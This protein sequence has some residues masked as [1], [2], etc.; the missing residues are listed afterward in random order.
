M[1][2]KVLALIDGIDIDIAFKNSYEAFHKP[3]VKYINL[4]RTQ[5]YT[6]KIYVFDNVELNEQGYLVNP[7]NH[8]YNFTTH[9]LVGGV[10]N[11]IFE[12]QPYTLGDWQ[13]C[14]YSTPLNGGDGSEI[15]T[16]CNLKEK[17]NYDYNTSV[18]IYNMDHRQVHTIIPRTDRT[19]ILFLEQYRDI[20]EKTHYLKPEF[21]NHH[22]CI[23]QK[24]KNIAE[25]TECLKTIRSLI[26]DGDN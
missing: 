21:D 3:C 6:A 26:V 16:R 20:V 19:T 5:N 17:S 22:N 9:I 2:S 23:H 8:A 18:D 1:K 14:E 7:H 25:F 15:V 11:V 10:R 12:V 24:F 13:L 4:V